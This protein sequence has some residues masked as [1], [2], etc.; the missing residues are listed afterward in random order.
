MDVPFD[1]I[2]WASGVLGPILGAQ[3]YLIVRAQARVSEVE[4]STRQMIQEAERLSGERAA[5]GQR[6]LDAFKLD[7][8]RTYVSISHLKDVEQR[9][10]EHLV[11]I[12]DKLTAGGGQPGCR[13]G[14][15]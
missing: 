13:V 6:E 10:T 5:A 9:I 8:A 3:F 12:E 2:A 15:R 14:E 4:R 11:R 1:L 7:V